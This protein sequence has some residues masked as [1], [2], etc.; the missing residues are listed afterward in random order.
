MAMTVQCDIVSAERSIFSGMVEMVIAHGVLGDLGVYP[1]HA[2]LLTQLN[3]G[4]VR[5]IKQGGDEEIFYVSGG[6]LEV[7]PDVV[8]VLADVA[9]RAH[10]MDEAAAQAAM[11]EARRAL[12]DQKA[13]ME[14]SVASTRLAEAAAQLRTIQQL[15]KK[16]GK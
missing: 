9:L 15:R 10:D 3:P 12:G 14:Y 4:P 5:V 2:P 6:F 7:Q 8:T 11:D 1:R 16:Y 13:E